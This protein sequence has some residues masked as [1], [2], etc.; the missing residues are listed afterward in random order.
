M[1][2]IFYL[3][4]IRSGTKYLSKLFREN[5]IDTC[6]RHEPLP[7]MFG[8]AI[9]A[10]STGNH[11]QLERLF[12]KKKKRIESHNKRHYFESNH[13]FLKSFASLAMQHYPD[14]KLVRIIRDPLMVAKSAVNKKKLTSLLPPVITHY[15]TDKKYWRWKFTGC[16]SVFAPFNLNELSEFQ[17]YILEWFEVEYRAQQF[18]SNFNKETDCF[19]LY[20]PNDLNDENKIKEMFSFFNL[21]TKT[22][23]IQFPRIKN[24]NHIPTRIYNED[25]EA[26]KKILNKL[27]REY[28][29]LLNSPV[30][31]PCDWLSKYVK[32]PNL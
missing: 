7:D 5:A 25:I 29:H 20:A 8:K 17:Y 1:N 2:K 13:S 6:S 27:P 26:F 11:K 3:G 23:A 4:N 19:T 22:E 32:N 14:M 16:E 10:C 31:K 15:K 28:S 21:N 30:Y 9:Y 12:V 18:L 24:K